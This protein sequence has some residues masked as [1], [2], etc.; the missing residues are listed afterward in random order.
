MRVGCDETYQL[1]HLPQTL[2]CLQVVAVEAWPQDDRVLQVRSVGQSREVEDKGSVEMKTCSKCLKDLPA[3][4]EYF[5]RHSRSKDGFQYWCKKCNIAYGHNHREQNK[6]MYRGHRRKWRR[7]NIEQAREAL[8]LWR[9]RNPG[10][11]AQYLKSYNAENPWAR[12]R[13]SVSNKIRKSLVGGK[14]GRSWELLVGYTLDELM[15]HLESQFKPGMSWDNFGE[16]HID[17]IRPVSDFDFTTTDDPEFKACWSL[18]NL[19]P[20]WGKDNLIKGSNCEAPP[21]P[22]LASRLD[23]RREGER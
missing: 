11:H 7:N 2:L 18:W 9:K 22:L 8:C 3:T 14:G 17:H 21:L 6:E 10:H 13:N 12:I 23:V 1:P 16:W 5:Y 4:E 15:A 20:L 19:Q